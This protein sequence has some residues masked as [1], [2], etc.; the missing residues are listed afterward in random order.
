MITRDLGC[1]GSVQITA[2]H[3]PFNRNGLK[4]FTQDGGLDAPDI[5][6]ILQH[7]QDGD[8]PAARNGSV[9]NGRLYGDVLRTSARDDS[10][11]RQRAGLRASARRLSHCRGRGQRRG[12]LLRAAT[13]LRPL[14]ADIS[15]SQFLEPDGHFPNHIPN[16]ENEA[17]MESAREAT[18]E[19]KA[20]LGVIFDTDVDRARRGGRKGRR[21]QPQPPVA[22]ASA[23]ALENAPAA[24][25]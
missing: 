20:D 16:P 10:E 17:A 4:F 9:R 7:A 2:S 11:G 14:G 22:I 6:A 1:D 15:G 8:K 18:L 12:R 19:A 25:S 5:E 23:I 13:C 24:R 3:H 21:D